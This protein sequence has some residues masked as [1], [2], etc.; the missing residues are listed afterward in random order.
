MQWTYSHLIALVLGQNNVRGH[1]VTKNVKEVKFQKVW[2]EL[3]LRKR[4]QKQ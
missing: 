2:S 4:F 1:S 3:E